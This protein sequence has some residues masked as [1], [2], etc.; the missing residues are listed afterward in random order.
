MREGHR[1]KSCSM[2]KFTESE[3]EVLEA[4]GGN[5][6]LTQ[7]YLARHDHTS[8]PRPSERDARAISAWI[9][10]VLVDKKYFSSQVAPPS[11]KVSIHHHFT[12]PP[13]HFS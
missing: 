12:P 2:G 11:A 8:T 1:V 9:R 10:D 7:R 3:V 13:L 6:V 4:L 5:E